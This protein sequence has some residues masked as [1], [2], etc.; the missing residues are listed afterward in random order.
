M[1]INGQDR[2]ENVEGRCLSRTPEPGEHQARRVHETDGERELDIRG[3]D[4]AGKRVHQ[5]GRDLSRHG[6]VHCPAD[7]ALGRSIQGRE[8]SP[9][10]HIELHCRNLPERQHKEVQR[11]RSDVDQHGPEGARVLCGREVPLDRTARDLQGRKL[12]ELLSRSSTADQPPPEQPAGELHESGDKGEEL[13]HARL[14]KGGDDL[15]EVQGLGRRDL[16]EPFERSIEAER[17]KEVHG[18]AQEATARFQLRERER[19]RLETAAGWHFSHLLLLFFF[20][21]EKLFIYLIF[22]YL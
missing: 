15:R 9:R 6:H 20:F 7:P 18:R 8:R 5:R 16:R 17:A 19:E 1:R 13:Q 4:G 21:F 14:Q 3:V 12:P 11:E 2:P 10:P 22:P